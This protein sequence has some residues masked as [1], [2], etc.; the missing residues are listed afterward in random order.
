MI[1]FKHII[2]MMLAIGLAYSA[3]AQLAANPWANKSPVMD[4]Q[5]PTKTVITGAKAPNTLETE[6]PDFVGTNSTWNTAMGQKMIAPDVNITNMLLMTQHL[7]NMGYQIPDG[8]DNLINTAPEKLRRQIM[9]S[10]I[11]LKQSS[12]P[13]ATASNAYAEIFERYTGL[14]IENLIENSLRI[15]DSRR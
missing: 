11:Y 12:H 4:K 15:I 5:V 3:S 1:G 14:S 6:L 9:A 13:V 2:P 7:R 10:M 8:I